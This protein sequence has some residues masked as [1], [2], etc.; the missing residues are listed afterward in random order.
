MSYRAVNLPTVANIW[1]AVCDF[2]EVNQVVKPGLKLVTGF[3]G[4]KFGS[5]VVKSARQSLEGLF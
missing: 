1:P 5:K 3:L 2:E 4:A